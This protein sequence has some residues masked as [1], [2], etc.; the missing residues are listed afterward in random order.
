MLFTQAM[1]K[2]VGSFIQIWNA[3]KDETAVLRRLTI[4]SQALK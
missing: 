2:F 3:A 1:I 4:K